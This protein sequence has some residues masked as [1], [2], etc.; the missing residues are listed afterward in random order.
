M[1]IQ[2]NNMGHF[3]VAFLRKFVKGQILQ[4]ISEYGILLEPSERPENKVHLPV[5]FKSS[6]DM[7]VTSIFSKL[8][9]VVTS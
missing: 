4:S 3:H 7:E 1:T 5:Y 8:P 6:A 9:T 2:A